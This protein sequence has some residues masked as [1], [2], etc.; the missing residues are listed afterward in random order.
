M[1]GG[2]DE[3][4]AILS[5]DANPLDQLDAILNLDLNPTPA[6]KPAPAAAA[7]A[8]KTADVD[9]LDMLNSM[10]DTEPAPAPAPAPTRTAASVRFILHLAS[11]TFS[12]PHNSATEIRGEKGK[13]RVDGA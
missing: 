7:A 4:Q 9:Y 1:L 2:D 8:A 6:P 13:D 11:T 10:L 3:M 12:S 5:S